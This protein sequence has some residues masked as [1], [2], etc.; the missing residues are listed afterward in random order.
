MADLTKVQ[1]AIQAANVPGVQGLNARASGNQIEI[2]GRADSI[3]AK[4][5]A[6]RM[7]T[8]K[9]GDAGI[10]NKIEIIQKGAQ[11]QAAGAQLGSGMA[12]SGQSSQS[13]AGRTHK[14]VKGDTLSAI[15]KQYYGNANDYKKIFEANKDQLKDPDKI[16]VGQTL[17]IP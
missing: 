3:A 4:Q 16:Q 17:R 9:F 2:H 12:P 7:V 8:E 10:V 5:S 14:V 13:S 1:Q 11:P 15:A 6:M